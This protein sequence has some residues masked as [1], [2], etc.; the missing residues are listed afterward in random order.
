MNHMKDHETLSKDSLDFS[1]VFLPTKIK[2]YD[3]KVT[4]AYHF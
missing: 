1:E 3:R 4:F 2:T